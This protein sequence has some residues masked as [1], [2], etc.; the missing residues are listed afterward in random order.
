MTQTIELTAQG[1][2]V[3]VFLGGWPRSL[4]IEVGGY[5]EGDLRLFGSDQIRALHWLLG[6][7]LAQDAYPDDRPSK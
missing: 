5:P 6:E 4:T 1:I 7:V 2:T 3:S